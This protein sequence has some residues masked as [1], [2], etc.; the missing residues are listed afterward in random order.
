MCMPSVEFFFSSS[1]NLEQERESTTLVYLFS[2][3]G[4]FKCSLSRVGALHRKNNNRKQQR[5]D[6]YII[7]GT[8][9]P[10]SR[11]G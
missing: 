9:T 1:G 3:S 7:G 2:G 8:E 10:L 4:I 11:K 6:V 5:R